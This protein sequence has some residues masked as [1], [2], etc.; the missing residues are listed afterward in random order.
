M[1][2]KILLT[3]IVTAL[4]WLVAGEAFAAVQLDDNLRPGNIPGID[5]ITDAPDD[6]NPE[7]AATKTLIL[8]V[9]RIASR[10]LIWAGVVTV[11]FLMVAGSN[12]I[13]AFGKDERIE[14]GKRGIFWALVGFFVILFSYAIVQAI[15][16][17]V[18]SLD[19][20]VT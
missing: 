18:L 19:V 11:A 5:V 17:V 9:G 1:I 10:V 12:Y 7:T 16:Q 6:A 2:K 20:S 8:F 3:I 14:K 4:F 15:I 13:L